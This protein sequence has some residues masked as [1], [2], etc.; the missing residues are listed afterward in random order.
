MMNFQLFVLLSMLASLLDQVYSVSSGSSFQLKMY[1]EEG[2]EWQESTK[3]RRYCIQCEDE[4]DEGERLRI[5][6]CNKD[7]SRQRFY[8]KD[9]KL[10]SKRNND[11]CLTYGEDNG[12]TVYLRECDDD[13]YDD[14]QKIGG[15]RYSG[16]FQLRPK[17]DE[18]KS[19]SDAS[20]LTINHHPKSNER[21]QSVRCRTA[22]KNDSGIKDDTSHWV[23]GYFDD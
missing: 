5:Q 20:C 1:W 7:T 6:R 19:S 18:D 23:V 15:F 2:T 3:E 21:L 9:G 14:R 17:D 13:Q 4:C 16:K 11:V 22:E 10:Q 8:F 12:D